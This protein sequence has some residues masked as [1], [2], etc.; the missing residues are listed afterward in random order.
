MST[1]LKNIVTKNATFLPVDV[2][3]RDLRY[4]AMN[5]LEMHLFCKKSELQARSGHNQSENFEKQGS[6]D[7]YITEMNSK[8]A[9]GSRCIGGHYDPRNTHC[10]PPKCNFINDE[11]RVLITNFIV[12]YYALNDRPSRLQHDGNLYPLVLTCFATTLK[13]LSEV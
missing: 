8:C 11:N 13:N 2:S 1:T 12:D 5:F 10:S 7:C 3:S 6:L 9:I 4:G